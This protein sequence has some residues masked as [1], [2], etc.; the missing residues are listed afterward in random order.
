MSSASYTVLSILSYGLS[1]AV[2]D[3]YKD[4]SNWLIWFK[5]PIRA[6]IDHDIVV[7]TIST[8]IQKIESVSML[9]VI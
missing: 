5:D 3:F 6:L 4:I 1:S 8:V 7:A 9:S 2:E